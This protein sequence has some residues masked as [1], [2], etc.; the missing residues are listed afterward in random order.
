MLQK[1]LRSLLNHLN[2]FQSLEPLVSTV[3]GLSG[4]NTTVIMSYE[5]RT[6]GNKPELQRRFFALMEKHFTQSQ[7]PLEDHHEVY[8]S[9]DILI[10]EFKKRDQ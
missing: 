2:L 7:I 8:S 3:K 4:A 10:H 5:Q 9:Q 6:D 1:M